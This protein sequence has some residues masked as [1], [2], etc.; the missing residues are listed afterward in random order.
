MGRTHVHFSTGL[1]EEAGG[2]ISGM[3][4]DAELL[5]YVDVQRSLEDGAAKWWISD[6]GVVLTEGGEKGMVETKYWKK[7]VGRKQEVGLLWED[8]QEVADLPMSVRGRKAPNGKGPRNNAGRGGRGGGR[9]GRS[10]RGEARGGGGR[11]LEVL[12]GGESL[13]TEGQ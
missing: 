6:N 11:E 13:S 10:G 1:P 12:G 9:G 8:G 3:R 5:V 4:A 2:V 7:V